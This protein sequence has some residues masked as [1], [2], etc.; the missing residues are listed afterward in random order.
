MPFAQEPFIGT[1]SQVIDVN[2]CRQHRDALIDGLGRML[3]DQELLLPSC[4]V[5]E[6][7]R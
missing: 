7:V 4:R 1:I 6:G 2:K 3:D 5:D